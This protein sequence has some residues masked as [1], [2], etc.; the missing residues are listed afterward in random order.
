MSLGQFAFASGEPRSSNQDLER[1]FAI[2]C[3]ELLRGHR[4]CAA[5]VSCGWLRPGSPFLRGQNHPQ[6]P[7]RYRYGNRLD[8]Q[9]ATHIPSRPIDCGK[10]HDCIYGAEYGKAE[11]PAALEHPQVRD[12]RQRF[13]YAE[14]DG[15]VEI[16]VRLKPRCAEQ[17]NKGRVHKYAGAP[18]A[19]RPRQEGL[20]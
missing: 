12:N 15:L 4:A 14:D 17:Q 7:G 2:S 10:P 5:R 1:Q 19:P 18:I 11:Q 8:H 6:R 3:F 13:P 20:P 16:G 9:R